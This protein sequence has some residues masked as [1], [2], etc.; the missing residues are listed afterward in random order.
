MAYKG[1]RGVLFNILQCFYH[2]NMAYKGYIG[3]LFNNS[4]FFG[5]AHQN[6]ISKRC[7]NQISYISDHLLGGHFEF[8]KIRNH[9][10]FI[11]VEFT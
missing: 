7:Q 8:F 1:Y 6:T 5:I 3:V 4:T 9:N 11:Y 2:I 10:Y